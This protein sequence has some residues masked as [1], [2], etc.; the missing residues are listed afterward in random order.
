M[1][2]DQK[3]LGKLS[4]SGLEVAIR[5]S[6]IL[7]E[8]GDTMKG[9]ITYLIQLGGLVVASV[10]F[11]LILKERAAIALLV[12]GALAWWTGAYLRKEGIL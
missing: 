7:A 10:G 9:K 2:Y 11:S 8:K 4:H 6:G 3:A 12:F 1:I 5:H